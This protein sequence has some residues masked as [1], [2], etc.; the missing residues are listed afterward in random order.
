MSRIE[1]ELEFFLEHDKF[2]MPTLDAQVEMSR[3]QVDM[4]VWS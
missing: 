2:E 1:G 4:Q 3:R